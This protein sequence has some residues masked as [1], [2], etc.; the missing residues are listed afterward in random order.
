MRDRS[1][2]A[3]PRSAFSL[4]EIIVVVVILAILAAIVIPQFSGGQDQAA[5]T[6]LSTNV[7]SIRSKT[8]SELARTGDWPAAIDS[9]W[10]LGGEPDHP[11][12][13]FG[14]PMI[15]VVTTPGLVHPVDKVLKA[16]VGGAYWYNNTNGVFRA[17]VVDQGSSALTID[18]YNQVNQSEE[19]S[20]GNY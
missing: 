19:A 6:A 11:N 7:S 3:T 15:Q 12:N 8:A 4:I 18:S 16:G 10:F 9:D 14:V 2:Q 13:G 5:I 20:L 1:T 17:R